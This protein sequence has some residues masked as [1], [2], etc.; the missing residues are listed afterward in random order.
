MNSTTIVILASVTLALLIIFLLINKRLSTPSKKDKE[1]GKDYLE[2]YRDNLYK[3][4]VDI[5]MK[6][7]YKKYENIVDLEMDI[8]NTLIIYGRTELSNKISHDVADS[9]LSPL[10]AKAIDEETIDK[11][12]NSI[13]DKLNLEESIQQ[14]LSTTFQ[15]AVSDNEKLE[16]EI[17]NQFD[18]K[19][20]FTDEEVDEN[21]ELEE[22]NI[23]PTEEELSQLNPPRE[24]G[25][26]PY[27]PN[28]ESMEIINEEDN[29][30]DI[31]Q[32]IKEEIYIDA[33]GRARNKAGKFVKKPKEE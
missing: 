28:D 20:F 18:S 9:K 15:E 25:E 21:T 29:T 14:S 8:I 24:D 32:E 17:T 19:E 23:Q 6:Y 13:I 7:D 22:Q 11:F 4:M 30:V 10:I 26:E 5:V 12:I 3:S 16:E 1:K 27:N 31:L 33:N 2:T